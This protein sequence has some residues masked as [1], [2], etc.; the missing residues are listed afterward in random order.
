[1]YYLGERIRFKMAIF[2]GKLQHPK[3]PVIRVQQ[4]HRTLMKSRA[5]HRKKRRETGRLQ[6]TLKKIL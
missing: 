6:A 1:M 2:G 4:A 3:D 5:K